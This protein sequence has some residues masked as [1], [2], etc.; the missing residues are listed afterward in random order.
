MA[1]RPVAVRN[2]VLILAL[3]AACAHPATAQ[4]TVDTFGELAQVLKPGNTVFVQD[5]KGERTKGKISE[6]SDASIQLMTGGFRNRTLTLP[7]DRVMRV[8]KVDSK[9]NGFVIGVIAGMVPGLVLGYGFKN[10]CENESGSH[11]NNAY[12]Y[13]GGVFGLAGGWIGSAIDGTI[14]GQT[15]VFR[16]P[17]VTTSVKF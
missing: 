12:A 1:A 5:E 7:A 11:C 17:G 9:W 8:S 15:L 6:L 14:D 10:W 13:T 4:T 3:I 2:G 16:R